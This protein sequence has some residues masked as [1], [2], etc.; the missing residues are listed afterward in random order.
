MSEDTPNTTGQAAAHPSAVHE[1][2]RLL[3]PKQATAL[4][5]I[6]A[7]ASSRQGFAHA[8]AAA[9]GARHIEQRGR[10]TA[11]PVSQQSAQHCPER[12]YAG[13][14]GNMRQYDQSALAKDSPCGQ[15]RP[16]VQHRAP[17][18]PLP[19]AYSRLSIAGDTM[20][21]ARRQTD[22]G[23]APAA[24]AAAASAQAWAAAHRSGSGPGAGAWAGAADQDVDAA[25]LKSQADQHTLQVQPLSV[26]VGLVSDKGCRTGRHSA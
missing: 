15:S 16:A 9:T 12:Y 2:A 22:Q 19:T 6:A 11:Q 18:L 5:A 13:P 24:A 1:Q 8:E 21:D 7:G 23:I 17:Q 26:E 25:K 3:R 14:K 4:E 20:A 10:H